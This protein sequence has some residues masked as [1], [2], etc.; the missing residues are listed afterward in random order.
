MNTNLPPE[1]KEK[2]TVFHKEL[3]KEMANN[4]GKNYQELLALWQELHTIYLTTTAESLQKCAIEYEVQ[5]PGE[6]NF[7]DKIETNSVVVE[8]ID[9]NTGNFFRRTLPIEYMETANG[10][11]LSGET[12]D[13]NPTQLVFYSETAMAKIN[14]FFGNGPNTPRCNHE[15]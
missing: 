7:P 6:N 14:E 8:I 10:I 9:Q 13:G 15:E 4:H 3:F 12:S 1:L 5:N 2:M 11:R